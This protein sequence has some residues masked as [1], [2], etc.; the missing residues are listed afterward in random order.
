MVRLPIYLD[1][2]STTRC[3]PRVVEAMLPFFT[4]DYGNAASRTHAFGWKAEAAVDEARSQIAQIIGADAKE[5]VF[6]SGATESDNLAIK[7]VAGMYGHKGKHII[8]AVT[9]HKA[10]LDVCKR[11]EREGFEITWLPVDSYGRVSADQVG[12]AIKNETILVS[13]MTANNEAGTLQPVAEIGRICKERG[14]IFHTDAAQAVGKIPVNID[15][16]QADLVSISAH[17]IYG[18]KGV[19]ALYV[20]RR[21]PHV[22]LT[23]IIDGGGHERGMRSGTL[24]VPNIV[25]FGTACSICSNEM[26]RDAEHARRLCDKLR[27]SLMQRLPEVELNGHPDERLPGNLNLSFDFIRGDALMMALKNIAISSGSACTSAN[28]EPSY[29]LRAMGISE[30]LAHGSLRF[31]VGRFNTEEEI[32]Y[33]AA[34]VVVQVERLRALNPLFQASERIG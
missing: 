29:V 27:V 25:G 9:E 4:E 2:N 7:G 12:A 31:G 22:R 28:V 18:P 24:P 30:D 11:L 33:V 23:P 21:N 16:I 10:V 13:I 17:K 14:V 1:N 26:Q 19:G 34:E 3:D 5:I 6:T 15:A 20:R 8:T 32:D